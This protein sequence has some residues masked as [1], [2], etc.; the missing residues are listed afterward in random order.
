MYRVKTVMHETT[1]ALKLQETIQEAENKRKGKRKQT[2][3]KNDKIVKNQKCPQRK[4]KAGP[5]D[6]S[7]QS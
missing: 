7:E 6:L 4:A 5:A 3:K 1:E 2:N